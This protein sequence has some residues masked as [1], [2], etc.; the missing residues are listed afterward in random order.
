MAARRQLPITVPSTD[1]AGPSLDVSNLGYDSQVV[2]VGTF[3]GTYAI[4]YELAPGTWSQLGAVFTVPTEAD[5]PNG[6]R[7]VRIRRDVYVSGAPLAYAA[8]IERG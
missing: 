3:D 1:T 6:A 8:G 2:F 5:I 4:E 7:A